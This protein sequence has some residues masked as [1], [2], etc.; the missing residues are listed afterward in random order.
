MSSIKRI[1]L[2]VVFIAPFSLMALNPEKPVPNSEKDSLPEWVYSMAQKVKFY[3]SLR[4]NIGVADNG[5]TGVADN[6]TRVG[7]Q[8][9]LPLVRSEKV[10]LDAIG[11]AEWGASLVDRDDVIR[12]QGDP[13]SQFA[14]QGNALYTRLGFV[15]IAND[16]VSYTF[17]KQWSAYSK[18]AGMTDNFLAFGGE[19]CGQYNAGTDGGVSGTGRANRA[20][21]L[22]FKF[23]GLEFAIQ[24]QGRAISVNDKKAFDAYGLALLYSVGGFTVGATYNEVR[25]GLENPMPDQAHIGDKAI[26]GALSYQND[27]L[28]IAFSHARLLKHE[29][30]QINDSTDYYY[31]G[32]GNELYIKYKFSQSRKW[33]VA[34][35]FN[36][37]RPDKDTPAGD[38][39]LQYAV[40]EL[41]YSFSPD[42][43]AFVT[44][45]I[46]NSHDISGNR[47]DPTVFGGG[48]R[49]S[50]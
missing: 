40:L 16:W 20:S 4:I 38:F 1:L 42:S 21:I 49:L 47:S 30:V 34:T 25:D 32:T 9:R 22:D 12:F 43:Y 14:E 35:G 17:G 5:H 23:A 31:D 11:T 29:K 2:A 28:T 6:A 33:H 18:V 44:T 45:R 37:L 24:G 26:C 10:K 36:Y 41:A 8:S 50:F 48:L 7:L 15:G 3:G 46:D 13:G 19:A 27:R 39:D